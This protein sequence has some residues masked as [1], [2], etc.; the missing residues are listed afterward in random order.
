MTIPMTVPAAR[1]TNGRSRFADPLWVAA[2]SIIGAMPVVMAIAHRSS[3]L[4]LAVAMVAALAAM[5]V[6]GRAREWLAEAA[7]A[8]RTPLGLA[9]LGFLGFAALSI[10]W[11]VVPGTSLQALAEFGLTLA[12][13]FV[14]ALALPQRMPQRRPLLLAFSTALACVLILLQ[15]WTDVAVRRAF[16]LR[17][18]EFIFNR[19]SLTV[20]VLSIPLAWL[21]L[22]SGYRRVGAGAL[23]LAAGT[24]VQSESGAAVLG[25]LAAVAVYALARY[26]GRAAVSVV[27]LCVAVAILLAPVIGAA[28]ERVLPASVHESLARANTRA[29]VEIWKT[30][31]EAVRQDPV[32]GKGFGVS[33]S[34]AETRA[35]HE[36]RPNDPSALTLWHPHNA[37]LQIWVELGLVGAA[38]GM[39]VVMLLLKRIARLPGEFQAVSLTLVAAIVVVSLVGHGAWQGWWPAAV[40]AAIVWLRAA[41]EVL[42]G[43][44]EV[45]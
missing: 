26:S 21:L 15:L 16:G 44:D 10:T 14:L 19:P 12:G 38:L 1:P 41:R 29:R 28:A 8:L 40:G 9:V 31:G 17:A 39:I 45:V 4:V 27:A 23:A 33:P 35:A 24:V 37:A 42:R 30:F 25:L 20:L 5:A 3:T 18:E 34:F 22:R 36:V 43:H 6:E 32:L 13:A 7:A 11:S 2:H